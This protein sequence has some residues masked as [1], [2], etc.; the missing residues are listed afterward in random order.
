MIFADK[1]IYL[2]KRNNWS[3]EELA[4]KLNVSRQSVSKWEGAQST[5]DLQK[6]ILLSELFGVTTDY[7]IKDEIENIEFIDIDTIDVKKINL[8]EAQEFINVNKKISK[9]IALAIYLCIL[10]PTG[11]L[12]LLSLNDQIIKN[13]IAI[14]LGLSFLI[15]FVTI[16]CSIF[17]YCDSITNKYDYLRIG[18]FE[19][20]YGV[21]G[22]VGQFK[23]HYQNTYTKYTILGIAI[24]ILSLLPLFVGITAWEGI[25]YFLKMFCLLLIIVGLGV[26]ILVVVSI[27][28][29]CIDLLL[30]K[31]DNQVVITKND[32][33]KKIVGRIFWLIILLLYFGYSYCYRNWNISWI[34]WPI[35]GIVYAIVISIIDLFFESKE[36]I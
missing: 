5:P 13:N 4:Q 35:S 8:E 25:G 9:L 34:I 22:M 36:V 33:I 12:F 15:I 23:K 7:L 27:N 11:L 32:K 2:R 1:I 20:E 17:I 28:Y 3:Q 16:A 10:S 24:C 21:K 14:G 31:E 29:E 26:S 18:E 6:I 30:K 19:V